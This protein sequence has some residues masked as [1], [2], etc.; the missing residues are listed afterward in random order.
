MLETNLFMSGETTPKDFP[1]H[2]ELSRP[3]AI[4]AANEKILLQF[5]SLAALRLLCRDNKELDMIERKTL[6]IDT[7]CTI[8]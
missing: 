8:P 2:E 1:S 7:C 5:H 3:T 4:R 6:N